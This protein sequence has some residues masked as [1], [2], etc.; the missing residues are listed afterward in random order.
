MIA[1]KIRSLDI[2]ARW[3]L[4]TSV[5]I[6][7]CLRNAVQSGHTTSPDGSALMKAR[8]FASALVALLASAASSNAQQEVK[9]GVLYPLSGPIAQI[10][11]DAVAAVRTALQIANEGADLPLPLAKNKGLPGLGGAKVTFIVVDHQGKPAIGQS[12]TE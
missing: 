8:M 2:I 4:G 6:D 5:P 3:T 7:E 10:G 11:L 9:I 1:C 12:E